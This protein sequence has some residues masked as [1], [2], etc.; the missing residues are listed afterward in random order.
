ML[1]NNDHSYFGIRQDGGE[2]KWLHN[3]A[4]S[5]FEVFPFHLSVYWH[6]FA[7]RYLEVV[8]CE[9]VLKEGVDHRLGEGIWRA[10]DVWKDSIDKK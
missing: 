2:A 10:G 4:R 9:E 6:C 5:N 8:L 7:G 1:R 3:I